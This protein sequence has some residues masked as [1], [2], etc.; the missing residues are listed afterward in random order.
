MGGAD[1]RLGV[2]G[3]MAERE[4]RWQNGV[5][6]MRKI[7]MP[8]QTVAG[9][10]AAGVAGAN[11]TPP[12]MQQLL[13]H[14]RRLQR[15]QHSSTRR[16][17]SESVLMGGAGEAQL[18]PDPAPLETHLESAIAFKEIVRVQEEQLV[19]ARATWEH[20]QAGRAAAEA[21]TM[22]KVSDLAPMTCEDLGS[23]NEAAGQH[24]GSGR[25]GPP[26]HSRGGP[27]S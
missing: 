12:T 16:A 5:Q 19:A 26:A 6:Q 11:R 8:Q 18:T 7:R 17:Q 27:R 14:T 9:G 13:Q 25:G 15:F 24:G 2:Q 1:E 10:V 22:G 23:R 21:S 4:R 20:G 3:Q